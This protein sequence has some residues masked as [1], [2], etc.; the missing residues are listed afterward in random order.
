[1]NDALELHGAS[2][3]MTVGF[4]AGLFRVALQMERRKE[5]TQT[6]RMTKK[7]I[8]GHIRL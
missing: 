7:W 8:F 6:F 1:M 5:N 2:Q 3:N 4:I